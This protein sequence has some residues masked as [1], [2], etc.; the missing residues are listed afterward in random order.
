MSGSGDRSDSGGVI[1]RE[2]GNRTARDSSSVSST[3][4]GS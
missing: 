3:V 4:N 1:S 2:N